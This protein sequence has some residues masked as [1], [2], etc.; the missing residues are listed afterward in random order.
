MSSTI[1]LKSLLI[2][3]IVSIRDG[4]YEENAEILQST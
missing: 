2:A 1:V 3:T 4:S